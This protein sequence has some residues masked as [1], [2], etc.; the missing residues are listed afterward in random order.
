MSTNNGGRIN[1]NDK[2]VIIKECANVAN[3]RGHNIFA[4]QDGNACFTG[5]EASKSYVC[6]GVS[7]NCGTNGT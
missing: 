3:G 4:I 2:D 7:K 6:D 5:T 1:S